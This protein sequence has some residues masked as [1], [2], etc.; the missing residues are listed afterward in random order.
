[1]KRPD[2][3]NTAKSTSTDSILLDA[4]GQEVLLECYPDGEILF[5]T[6]EGIHLEF[7]RK[8][9]GLI[10]A[11]LR[12]QE[13][14]PKLPREDE[15]S[16]TLPPPQRPP[17]T[18]R[19]MPPPSAKNAAGTDRQKQPNRRVAKEGPGWGATVI[20]DTTPLRYYYDKRD[21]ARGANAAH[22]VGEAGRIA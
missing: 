5:W 12:K 2:S 10:I 17:R 22:R 19:T 7:D 13:K 11:A 9:T 21:H 1:M 18:A 15:N 6:D 20:V 3:P 4:K 8:H 16:A 14:L